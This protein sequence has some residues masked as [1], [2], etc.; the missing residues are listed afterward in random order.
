MNNSLEIR[1]LYK[2]YYG[3]TL[4]NVCLDLPSGCVMGLIGE[5]GAG[6][7]TLFKLIL[8]MINRDGGYINV[9][10]KDNRKDFHLT[11]QDLGIVLDEPVFQGYL[12]AESISRIMGGI[13]ISW[14]GQKF[15]TYLERLNVPA[16]KKFDKLSSGMKMKLSIAIA[17]SHGSK[18]LLFDEAMRGLDPVSRYEVMDMIYEYTREED[19]SALISSHIVSDLEKICD[20]VA[21]L[22][23]GRIIMCDEKDN[24]LER[25]G[26]IFCDGEKIKSISPQ[27]IKFKRETPYG[28]EA[29]LDREG[30]PNDLN[31]T[32]VGLE[33][34]FVFTV[35]GGE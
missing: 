10:G 20:Y 9:L 31:F 21:F 6:K 5:N 14:D 35:K 29:I 32:P 25:Y 18:L 12:T 1:H 13:F 16:N 8:D 33:D 17:M 30:I 26:R 28:V 7:T 3:F 24:L 11:K 23:K 2:R 15:K 22:H 19:C 27:F 4:D 34:V